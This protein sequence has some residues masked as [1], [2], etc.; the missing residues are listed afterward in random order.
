MPMSNP[1]LAVPRVTSVK[2]LIS[3]PTRLGCQLLADALK[4]SENPFEILATGISSEDLLNHADSSRADVVLV[5]AHLSD[6]PLTGLRVL[7]Q[8]RE[9]QNPTRRIL[10][11][12]G[13][14]RV[15]VL[16]AFRAGAHGVFYQADAR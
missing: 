12:D 4:R 14:D 1:G 5:S 11:L 15:L 9:R 10:L 16:D 13:P 7:R 2:L 8:M 3:S 6:G